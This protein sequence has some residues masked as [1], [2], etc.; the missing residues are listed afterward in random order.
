MKAQA[1]STYTDGLREGVT[2]QEE[3]YEH[4]LREIRLAVA[5]LHGVRASES[6][7][8]RI[9]VSKAIERLESLL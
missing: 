1:M 4:M 2:P 7:L 5:E 3:F 6:K 8:D 9:R